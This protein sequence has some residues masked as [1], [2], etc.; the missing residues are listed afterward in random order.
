MNLIEY[1]NYVRVNEWMAPL[2]TSTILDHH[3]RKAA[4][5]MARRGWNCYWNFDATRK[6][7]LDEG[8]EDIDYNIATGNFDDTV[9]NHILNNKEK[10][11]KM[12]GEYTH[13]GVGTFK[14][15]YKHWCILYGKIKDAT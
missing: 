15:K 8:F 6:L 14:T 2:S 11:V 1:H 5:W 9:I 4:H 3:A 10:K 12:F 13:I 7:L